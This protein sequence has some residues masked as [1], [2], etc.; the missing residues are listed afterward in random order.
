LGWLR[1]FWPAWHLPDGAGAATVVAEDP[2]LG[3]KAE[4]RQIRKTRLR[5][6]GEDRG[7][8]HQARRQDRQV[9]AAAPVL[10]STAV[11]PPAETTDSVRVVEYPA[12]AA[13]G[14][15][16]GPGPDTAPSEAKRLASAHG[17][18]R[19]RALGAET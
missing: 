1:W 12:R 8:E 15:P 10:R 5:G 17:A 16:L 14:E 18:H 2:A 6:W 13:V 19:A 11:R 4:C 9:R 3:C 7:A